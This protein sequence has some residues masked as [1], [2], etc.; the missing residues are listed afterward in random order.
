TFVLRGGV[1]A[2]AQTGN[3]VLLAINAVGK[4]FV[5]VIYYFIPILAF[6]LGVLIT[7]VIKKYYDK[8]KRI[9][10][11]YV[12]LIFEAVLLFVV[13]FIPTTVSHLTSN[14]IISFICS[15][16]VNSFRSI[17][18]S[19]YATTMCTGNLRSAGEKFFLFLSKKDKSAGKTCGKYFMVI[20]FFCIGAGI[21]VYFSEK[22]GVRSVW[23][24]SAILLLTAVIL[25]DEQRKTKN[26][27]Q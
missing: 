27:I 20:V 10:H 26:L 23:I 5:K 17:D 13:G 1:F 19:P 3:M 6:F 11:E 15:M 4:D 21:G 9:R 8:S 25:I 14:V 7:E 16:Q 2:N 18:G 24:C 12:V 22:Y